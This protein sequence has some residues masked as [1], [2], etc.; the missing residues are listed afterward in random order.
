[1]HLLM[2]VELIEILHLEIHLKTITPFMLAPARNQQE[3]T[4]SLSERD[5]RGKNRYIVLGSIVFIQFT[6]CEF[7][8]DANRF[9]IG[10]WNIL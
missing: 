1:M 3:D 6:F 5:K 7:L 10:L 2:F 8:H 9:F 4:I